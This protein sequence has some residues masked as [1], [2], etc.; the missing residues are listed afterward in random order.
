M[1]YGTFSLHVCTF[2]PVSIYLQDWILNLWTSKIQ[3]ILMQMPHKTQSIYVH[4]IYLLNNVFTHHFH[5]ARWNEWNPTG[6]PSQCLSQTGF[7][8]C[9]IH[10]LA[11]W[12]Y[13]KE[14]T[15]L[16]NSCICSRQCNSYQFLPGLTAIYSNDKTT[17][18]YVSV[19]IRYTVTHSKASCFN[20][21]L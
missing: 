18:V 8:S 12:L 5:S 4:V 9:W 13:F 6:C 20:N 10:G 19:C 17:A 16:V 14:I 3:G 7:Y 1:H 11:F 2:I 21:S 15:K